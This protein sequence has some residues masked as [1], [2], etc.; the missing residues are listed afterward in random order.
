MSVAELLRTPGLDPLD[1]RVLL[2]AALGTTDADL[3]AHPGRVPDER[4]RVRFFALAERRR[5]GEPIAYLIGEREFYSLSFK[6]TPAV[7][8]PRPETELLVETALERIA[9]N[10][11]CR[12]LDLGT[13]SGC[14]AVAI[15]RARPRAR[16]TASDVSPAALAIAR[17]NAAAHGAGI[18]FV[19]SDWFAALAGRRYDVIVSNPPYVAENDAH[20]AHGDLRF[21]PPGALTAGPSGLAGIETIVGQAGHY[22]AAGGT[23]LFE[24]GHE[25]GPRSRVLLAA[26]GFEDTVTRSDLSGLERVSGGRFDGTPRQP[27]K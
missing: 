13:G 27:L 7:L 2:R 3:A 12:V 1:A 17:E 22:L 25:Q 11:P 8:I 4:A 20:L 26:H 21:E 18:E 10:T 15:A 19:E 23:L 6:V 24:H 14:V 9:A 5:A 16:V